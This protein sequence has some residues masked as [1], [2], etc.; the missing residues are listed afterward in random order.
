MPEELGDA[1]RT[2]AGGQGIVSDRSRKCQLWVT[3]P[4]RL[5]VVLKR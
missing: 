4:F 5:L 2:R 3:P 1:A